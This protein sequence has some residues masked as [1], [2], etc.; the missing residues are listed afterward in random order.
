VSAA[1]NCYDYEAKN[2][3]TKRFDLALLDLIFERRRPSFAGLRGVIS[4]LRDQNPKASVF[5][6]S[7]AASHKN[8]VKAMQLGA[9]DFINKADC[10]PHELVV[11]VEKFFASQQAAQAR[12]AELGR[13]VAQNQAAWQRDFPGQIVV[14]VGQEVVLTAPNRMAAWIQ[15]DEKLAQRPGWPEE[16]DMMVVAP[17]EPAGPPA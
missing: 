10:A 13:L 14:L 9:S 6:Y 3:H 2:L 15:Y 7:G 8:I 1:R 17:R 16:P 11:K 4:S 5:I 12:R